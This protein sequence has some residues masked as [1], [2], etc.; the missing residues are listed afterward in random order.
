MANDLTTYGDGFS[1][2]ANEATGQIVGE[3]VRFSKGLFLIGKGDTQRLPENLR[4]EAHGTTAA[5]IKFL[6]NKVVDQR[7]GF[8]LPPREVLGDL[9]ERSWER[10]QE[11]KPK[12]PWTCQQ[13][14]YLL[15]R[16]SGE[17]FTFITSSWGGRKA[18]T[19]VSRQ[20]GIK[21]MAVGRPV[22]AVIKL[23]PDFNKTEKYGLVPAPKLEIVG[24]VGPD[25]EP[26]ETALAHNA[27]EPHQVR[28]MLGA[29]ARAA[30]LDDEIPF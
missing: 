4:L 21:R 9:D 13:Y 5:W 19:K 2:A 26:M 7:N 10:D 14:L 29:P 16:S 27:I 17:E 30:D 1:E 20:I 25:G 6:G 24:W 18:I 23:L 22:I 12:D 8:P 28:E 11:G 15:N 3:R